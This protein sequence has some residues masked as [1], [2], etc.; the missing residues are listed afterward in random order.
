MKV[1]V[2]RNLHK[3]CFSVKALEGPM[4]GKVIAHRNHLEL[5]NVTFKVSET[6]RLRV[7]ASGKKEVHA[8]VVGEWADIYKENPATI[9]LMEPVRYNPKESGQFR[10]LD[11]TPIKSATRVELTDGKYIFAET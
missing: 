2:Y 7:V 10:K 9:E 8:G 11:G 4:K 6:T 3:Q 1:F 5:K